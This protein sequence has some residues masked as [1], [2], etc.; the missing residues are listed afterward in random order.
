MKETDDM[1]LFVFSSS[2]MTQV[3]KVIQITAKVGGTKKKRE[4]KKEKKRDPDNTDREHGC[5]MRVPPSTYRCLCIT[6]AS[7]SL[8]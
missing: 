2:S 6:A 8:R 4:R 5:G 7:K 1:C 3:N